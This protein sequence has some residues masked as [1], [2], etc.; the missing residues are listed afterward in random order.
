MLL[1]SPNL[2]EYSLFYLKLTTEKHTR[3]NINSFSLSLTIL[4]GDTALAFL[5]PIAVSYE[6]NYYR[7]MH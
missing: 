6:L 3:L 4:G 7:S 1:F 2:A 5:P